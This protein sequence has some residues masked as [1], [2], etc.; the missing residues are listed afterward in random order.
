MFSGRVAPPEEQV[1]LL[2]NHYQSDLSSDVA[3]TYRWC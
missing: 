3:G 1:M 2:Y